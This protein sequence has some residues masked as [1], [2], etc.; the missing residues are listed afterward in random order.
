MHSTTNTGR[1]FR[2]YQSAAS[3]W[4]EWNYTKPRSTYST[5]FEWWFNR[6]QRVRIAFY[7][8][9][10][11]YAHIFIEYILQMYS[12]CLC[13]C[14]CMCALFVC[15]LSMITMLLV[16]NVR[17]THDVLNE[18]ALKSNHKFRGHYSTTHMWIHYDTNGAR[19][20][21]WYCNW[22]EFNANAEPLTVWEFDQKSMSN[23]RVARRSN[24][25]SINAAGC[26]NGWNPMAVTKCAPY[27]MTVQLW[28]RKWSHR[29]IECK[30][31]EFSVQMRNY[32]FVMKCTS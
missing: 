24:R 14:V 11:Q 25:N 18:H 30:C 28:P 7:I 15:G 32:E 13:A 31:M 10:L 29:R 19:E 17:Q 1:M 5:H 3:E 21:I 6:K 8:A 26:G 27:S 22:A 23:R 9:Y 2:S 4:T 16:R 12:T 20:R